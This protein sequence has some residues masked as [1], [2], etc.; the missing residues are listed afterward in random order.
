[1]IYLSALLIL[2]NMFKVGQNGLIFFFCFTE[3][4]F[5]FS[6]SPFIQISRNPFNFLELIFCFVEI[7]FP[8]FIVK[9]VHLFSL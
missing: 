6:K 3:S 8:L 9:I 7:L 5:K 2:G 1:M 4:I